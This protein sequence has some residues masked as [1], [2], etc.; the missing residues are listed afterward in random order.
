MMMAPPL[1]V[2][3]FAFALCATA[4]A[5]SR[6]HIVF[7]VSDDLGYADVGFHGSSQIPTPNLDQLA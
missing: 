2:L 5:A 3:A 1:R 4:G 7:I 6:P